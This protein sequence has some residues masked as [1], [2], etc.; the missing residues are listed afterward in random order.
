MSKSIQTL[1][2]INDDKP[3]QHQEIFNS[4]LPI[5]LLFRSE[6]IKIAQTI[7]KSSQSSSLPQKIK[8]NISFTSFQ[9]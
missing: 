4:L 8:P 9:H 2:G 1:K 7:I 3:D 6:V 5:S